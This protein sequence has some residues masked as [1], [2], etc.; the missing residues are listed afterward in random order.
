MSY[1][2]R[3]QAEAKIRQAKFYPTRQ[4]F[5]ITEQV[6]RIRFVDPE[7]LMIKHISKIV[8]KHYG[9]R[10][11]KSSATQKA[12]YMIYYVCRYLFSFPWKKIAKYCGKVAHTTVLRGARIIRQ[13]LALDEMLAKNLREIRGKL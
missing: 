11:V 12:R 7:P 13:R 4:N 6:K 10:N 3:L 1:V 2:E 5:K 9:F 8:F